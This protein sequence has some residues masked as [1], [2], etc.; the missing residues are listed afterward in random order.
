[1][2]IDAKDMHYTELARLVRDSG[3]PEIKIENC[4]GQRY[5]AAGV[6]GKKIHIEGTPGNALGAYLDGSE[7]NVRGSAQDATA[8]TMNKGVIRVFGNCGDG[9]GYGMRGGKLFIKG[10]VGYRAGIHMKAYQDAVPVIVVG[11]KTGSFLGEYQA[12]GLIV[13]L[14]MTENDRP[15][16][17]D[18]CGTGMHGGKIVLKTSEVPPGLPAQVNA[19]LATQEDMDEIAPHIKEFCGIFGV[20]EEEALLGDFVVLVPNTANPYKSHYTHH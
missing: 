1:M 3:Y 12:G 13:V 16:T 15:I 17:G 4:C 7:I 18:F 6:K 14:G 8:D 5:I 10:D 19:R 9:A 11:G 2:I 20:N